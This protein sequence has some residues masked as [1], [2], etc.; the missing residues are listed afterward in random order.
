MKRRQFV[1]LLG[2]AAAAWP[3]AAR[4]QQGAKMRR[5]GVLFGGFSD[6]DPE[7]RARLA[8]F[9]RSLGQLGWIEGRNLQI[10]VRIGA[11]DAER[12][13]I[14]AEELIGITPNLLM[15][16]SSPAL[17]ALTKH[18]KGVPIVFV[19]ALDPVGSGFVTSLSRPAGNATGF[20]SFD[21]EITGKWLGLL[22]EISPTM[23]R[24]L[25]LFDHANRAFAQFWRAIEERAP[26]LHLKA[27]AGVVT[28]ARDIEQTIN[29][30]T[31]EGNRGL[32][33]MGTVAAAH[34]GMLTNLALQRGLPSIYPFAYFTR[35]GGLMSYGVDGVDLWQR[36][37]VYADRILSGAKP[38]DLPVQRPTKFEFVINIKTAKALG[39][40][41]PPALL[42]TADE[43][44]E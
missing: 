5:I 12:V 39:L 34:R 38:A 42:G 30:Y 16:N 25:V 3:L 17:A 21:P 10:D 22:R 36:A 23:D 18:N 28:N 13:R 14:Y 15:A 9:T 44:I 24:V 31:G 43:V 37:T 33:C 41:V 29:A 32:I 1:T 8:A 40:T 35:I 26:S 2:G 20:S 19:N 27:D 7:P 11:G 6:T 4:A